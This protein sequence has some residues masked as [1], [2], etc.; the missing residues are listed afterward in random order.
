MDL[1]V[2]GRADVDDVR[3]FL[4]ACDLTPAGLDE[5]GVGCGRCARPV[6]SWG[7]PGSRR[8]GAGAQVLLRSV[9]VAPA[10]RAAGAGTRFAR[11]ALD[12]AVGLGARRAWLFS[13]RS[14]PFWQRLGFGEADRDALVAAIPD[15][16]QVRLSART[17]RLEREVAWGLDLR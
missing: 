11:H 8:M 3:D 12:Q 4:R 13:R 16:H 1:A 17:G 15:A 5:P 9:A 10:G 14:G 7:R 2:V 6:K